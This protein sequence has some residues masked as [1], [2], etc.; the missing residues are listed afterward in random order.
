MKNIEKWLHEN[1]IEYRRENYGNP[2]YFND[3]FSVEGLQ[4]AFYF[5][6]VGNAWEKQNDL[7]KFMKRKKAYTCIRSR[8]GAGY[9]Y[10]IMTVFNARRLA[11]HEKSIQEAVE[12]FWQDEH[13]RRIQAKKAV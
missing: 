10:C 11:E 2:Y 6:S 13:A 9:T 8:F 5:D 3:G 1:G 7:E 12:R 4:I